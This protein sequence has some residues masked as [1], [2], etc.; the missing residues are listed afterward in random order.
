MTKIKR[1]VWIIVVLFIYI[2]AMCAYLAPRN[3]E[4]SNT[5]K[6]VTVGASYVVLFLLW[7]VLRR[8]ERIKERR[9]N[10]E[11][12]RQNQNQDKN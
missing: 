1:S 6:I 9:M 7:L 8:K 11:K 2:T 12:E 4:I 5:E 10:E 3:T